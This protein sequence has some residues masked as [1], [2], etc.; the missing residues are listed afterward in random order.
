[1]GPRP[2]AR[3]PNRPLDRQAPLAPAARLDAIAQSHA[4]CAAYGLSRIERPEFESLGRA[5]M[6]VVRER[7]RRLHA[8]AAPVMEM[9]H[10]QIVDTSSMVVLCDAAG[11][12]LHRL[13]DDDFLARASKVALS[14]GVNWSEPSKGTNA[15][16]TALFNEAPTLVHA[17]DHYLH[18][19]HFLTCSAAPILDPRGN[20]LGVLD[21]TGDQR[22]YHPHTMAL[23]TMSARLIENHWLVNDAAGPLRLHFHARPECLGTLV[24]GVLA[25]APDGRIVG[26]N[27][28][29]LDLLGVSSASL[30]QHS[31]ASL[32]GSSVAVLADHFRSP[33]APLLGLH[34]PDGRKVHVQARFSAQPWPR[35]TATAAVVAATP[36][37]IASALRAA[38]H[39]PRL[40][41]LDTGDA[42]VAAAL[43]R[44]R[45]VMDRGIPILIEGHT[46]TGKEWLARA[47]HGQSRRAGFPFQALSADTLQEQRPSAGGG[48]VFI[49]EVAE[50]RPAQQALLLQVLRPVRSPAAGADPAANALH[51]ICSTRHDLRRLIEAGRFRE[52][53][54]HALNGLAVRLPPLR[55]R[56]DVLALAA[57]VLAR[58]SAPQPAPQLSPDV[59][60]LFRRHPWPGN[61]HQLTAVLRTAVALAGAA[62]VIGVEHLDDRFV[63]DAGVAERGVDAVVRAGTGTLEAIEIAGIRRALEASGGNVSAASRRL[64]I[65]RTT[66]Y[67]KLRNSPG[68]G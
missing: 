50:L 31:L 35:P 68:R 13:G 58:E 29:A 34:L 59:V 46:G 52:D 19:N 60:D 39:M 3:P 51:L 47:V 57:R 14:P 1:M 9:L 41:D 22:S 2:P 48:T 53:L 7:N 30:R 49:D 27:R 56:S 32:L 23:V 15:I 10:G 17:D 62:A 63:A 38:E 8:H 36:A 6:T 33:P 42:R 5:D 45:R 26:A 67:R 65:S 4:R 61:L 18:A 37:P 28:A 44:L 25:V 11:T 43:Q 64:G 24:E 16:G 12:I 55:E 54:F 40:A 66:L 21:V 20:L